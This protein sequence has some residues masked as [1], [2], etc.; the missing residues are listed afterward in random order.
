[1]GMYSMVP[2]LEPESGPQNGTTFC[3]TD[4]S[5]NHKKTI[6][7]EALNL[8]PARQGILEGLKATILGDLGGQ[9]GQGVGG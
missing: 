8:G 4:A 3:P 7:Q 9:P 1:M 6:N 5:K 2:F